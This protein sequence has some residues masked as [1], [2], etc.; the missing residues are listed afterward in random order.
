[1]HIKYSRKSTLVLR[2]VLSRTPIPRVD[3]VWLDREGSHS[4]PRVGLKINFA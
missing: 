4:A 2:P 3:G 1:M